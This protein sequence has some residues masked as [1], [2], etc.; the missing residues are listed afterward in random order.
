MENSTN[1][2]YLVLANKYRPKNFSDMIGQEIMVRTLSNAIKQ[3]RIANAFLLTGIRGIGKTTTA[4]IIAKVLNCSNL[5]NINDNFE[6]CGKCSNCSAI[7]KS[8]HP[9]IL[10]IDAA[11]RTGVDDMRE[12]IDNVSYSPS[13][14]KYRI[15]IIDEV[16]MLSKNAFN[17]L[18]KTLEEPPSHVKFI[19]ATTEI[20]KIP[21]TILSRCQR[22]DLRRIDV[23]SLT[24]HLKNIY[25]KENL[26]SDTA[27][28]TLIA[29]VAQGSVRDALSLLDQAIIHCNG[30]LTYDVVVN[31]LGLSDRSKIIDLYSSVSSGNIKESID[32]LNQIYN[33]GNDVLLII[34]DMLELVYLI[35]KVKTYQNFSCPSYLS[36]EEFAVIKK[37][38]NQL[39]L[40]YLTRCWQLI[41]NS[42]DEINKAPIDLI[43]AEM[44]LI[45]IAFMSDL[46]SPAKIINH[47]EG[48]YSSQKINSS[49]LIKKNESITIGN[50]LLAQEIELNQQIQLQATTNDLLTIT[51]F[52]AA[53]ELFK[54]NGEIL[55]YSWL[56][57]E[58]NLVKF[59]QGRIELRLS[60]S[61][62][63]NFSQRISQSLTKWTSNPWLIIVSKER[64]QASLNQIRMINEEKIKQEFTNH[65]EVAKI[66][67]LFPGAIVTKVSE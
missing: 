43:A 10:E 40:S 22:F 41:I 30:N 59:Q 26:T 44:L 24:N 57:N 6:A 20:R 62:P 29:K 61:L 50:N 16:H 13:M 36:E 64:G 32:I 35:S 17:A 7:T 37:L 14:A 31:M 11:S 9:D 2:P 1:T 3:N 67:E 25:N 56:L 48:N 4:R 21:I 60:E 15:Y 46:P 66:L 33:L 53:V 5:Q 54:K 58:V 65:P 38:S 18:L 52:E 42:I 39:D 23:D 51:S 55:L 28:L 63:S 19:F 45:K 47:L 34:Q 27:S 8:S 49:S 12:I